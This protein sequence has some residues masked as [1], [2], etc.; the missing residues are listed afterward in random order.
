MLAISNGCPE[1]SGI[2]D[3]PVMARIQSAPENLRV[4]LSA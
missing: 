3:V 2:S 4:N 1:E